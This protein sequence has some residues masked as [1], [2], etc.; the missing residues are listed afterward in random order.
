MTGEMIEEAMK[1]G[2]TEEGTTG[3]MTEEAMTG[4][5]TEEAM[6]EEMIEDHP[7]VMIATA[8][9]TEITTGPETTGVS[10]KRRE[11]K[12]LSLRQ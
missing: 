7:Q 4:G 8:E 3:G 10:K 9:M 6:T 5:M 11:R 1:G 12:P 2:M